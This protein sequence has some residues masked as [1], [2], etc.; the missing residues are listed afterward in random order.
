VI[1]DNAININWANTVNDCWAF[2]NG[3]HMCSME[4][5]QRACGA[6]F[7]VAA[8]GWLSD[9]VADGIVLATNSATCGDFEGEV[10]KTLTRNEYCCLEYEKY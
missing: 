5:L 4:E 3:A 9:V 8:N 10:A 7:V 1:R 2:Y 6:G